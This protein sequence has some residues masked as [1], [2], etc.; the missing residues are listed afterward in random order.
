MRKLAGKKK[1]GPEL[2]NLLKGCDP[3]VRQIALALRELVLGA[4]PGSEEVLYS[5]YA[6]VIVFK[7]PNIKGGAFCYIAAYAHHVNLGFYRGGELPD[8]HR[9]MKGTGKT[10]R[11]IR[12]QSLNNIAPDYLPSYVQAAAEHARLAP[13]QVP[14]RKG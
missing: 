12:F 6:E 10:M 1:P 3:G 13:A 7:I 8:P 4:E 5:V 14:R 2:L 11:H 9:A